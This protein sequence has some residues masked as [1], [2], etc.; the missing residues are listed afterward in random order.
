MCRFIAQRCV[1]KKSIYTMY[2]LLILIIMVR[3]MKTTITQNESVVTPSGNS[4]HVVVPKAWIGKEAIVTLKVKETTR[5]KR[6]ALTNHGKPVQMLLAISDGWVWR[7]IGLV[8]EQDQGFKPFILTKNTFNS[9]SYQI[10]VVL[11]FIR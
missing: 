11:S 4:S 5:S 2:I 7:G 9:L 1:I 6:W 10:M 8:H 3:R